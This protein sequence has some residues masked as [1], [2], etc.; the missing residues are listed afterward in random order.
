M[1]FIPDVRSKEIE[2]LYQNTHGA[3]NSPKENAYWEGYLPE[4]QSI[5]ITG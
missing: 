5:A 4:D 2:P 1:S 3:N